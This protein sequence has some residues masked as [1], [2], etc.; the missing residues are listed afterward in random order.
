M[1]MVVPILSDLELI[2]YNWL[3][4][5]KIVF[6]YGVSVRG[7][8]FE[9]GGAKID[10]TLPERNIAIRVQGSYWHRGVVPEGKDALQREMLTAEGWTVVDIWGDDILDPTR[11]EQ[12]MRL[13]LQGREML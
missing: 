4:K 10:F 8:V 11:L 9:I 12:T 3:T 2:V 7:G 13:A 1:V 6:E 5:R